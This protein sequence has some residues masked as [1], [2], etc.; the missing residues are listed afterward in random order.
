MEKATDAAAIVETGM[1]E[2]DKK[3]ARSFLDRMKNKLKQI[4]AV[5]P[6]WSSNCD[7]KVSAC[8]LSL[9][10]FRGL[11]GGTIEIYDEDDEIER[12][13]RENFSRE[14]RKIFEFIAGY[15]GADQ[16]KT[17]DIWYRIAGALDV[18]RFY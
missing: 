13:C 2:V 8:C 15:T 16:K 9:Q 5:I 6:S 4:E 12:K 1:S 18:W 17:H 11:D 10:F 14:F 3:L 7:V